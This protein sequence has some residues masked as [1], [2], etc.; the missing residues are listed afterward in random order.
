MWLI[1]GTSSEYNLPKANAEE[2][3]ITVSDLEKV[4]FFYILWVIC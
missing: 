3:I 2:K 1:E 4:Y